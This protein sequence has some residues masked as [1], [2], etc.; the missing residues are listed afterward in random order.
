M[1]GEE[2]EGRGRGVGVE[3][4]GVGVGLDWGW[5]CGCGCCCWVGIAEWNGRVGGLCMCSPRCADAALIRGRCEGLVDKLIGRLND[6][7]PSE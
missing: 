7:K 4:W 6:I 3:G 5:G 2:G 1:D